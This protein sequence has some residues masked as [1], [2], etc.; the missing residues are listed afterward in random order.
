MRRALLTILLASCYTSKPSE[1]TTPPAAAAVTVD[2]SGATMADDCGDGTIPEREEQDRDKAFDEP[3]V[4]TSM[5]L[6]VRSPRE[7]LATT[8]R[9]KKVELVDPSG[10][11]LQTLAS[12]HPSRWD[13]DGAYTA[14]NEQVSPGQTLAASYLLTPPDWNKVA[15]GRYRA[16]TKVFQLRVTVAVGDPDVRCGRP[17]PGCTRRGRRPVRHGDRA[18]RGTPRS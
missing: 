16:N 3:C 10:K 13:N 11:V 7:A 4:P 18:G 17:R 1:R 9:I 5:Q 14:W 12:R 15:G 8:I 2:L 6:S